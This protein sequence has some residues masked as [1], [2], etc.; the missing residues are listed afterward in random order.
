[1]ADLR[2]IAPF[3]LRAALFVARFPKSHAPHARNASLSLN[4]L[5]IPH[6]PGRGVGQS[7]VPPVRILKSVRRPHPFRLK[8]MCGLMYCSAQSET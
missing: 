6:S 1:M 8:C 3:E 2:P 4:F 5:I 7:C